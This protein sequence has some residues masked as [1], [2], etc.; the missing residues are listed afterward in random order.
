MTRLLNLPQQERLGCFHA[1]MSVVKKVKLTVETS[2]SKRDLFSK[3]QGTEGTQIF[4][5]FN[6]NEHSL[7]RCVGLANLM[8]FLTAFVPIF[9]NGGEKSGI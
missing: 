1:G 6:L 4:L 3:S 5:E 8:R 7:G 9:W 2:A